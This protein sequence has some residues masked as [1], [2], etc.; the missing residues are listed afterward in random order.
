M[1]MDFLAIGT[2]LVGCAGCAGLDSDPYHADRILDHK[3][4][5]APPASMLAQPGPMVAGPGPGV[6]P[7][8][9]PPMQRPLATMKTQIRFVRPDGMSIGWLVN[10]GYAE[11]QIVTPGLYDFQQ[12]ATYRLKLTNIPQ[13]E[14]LALYP[15]LQVYPAHP[16]TD[17][18]LAHNSVPIEITQEDLDQIAGS[19]FVTKVIYLPDERFQ[20]FAIAGVETL[21]STRLDPGFDPVAEADRRGTIMVVLRIGNMDL[22]VPAS[23]GGVSQAVTQA[24]YHPDG[25]E[26]AFTPPMPISVMAVGPMG[27]PGAMIVGGAGA[28]GQPPM[29]PI[30]GMGPTPVWGQT[31]TGTPIGLPGPPHLP[32]GAPA[33]L[34]S[35]TIRNR[36][37]M[38]LPDPV[39]HMLMDVKHNP[40]YR[41]PKPVKYIEYTESH[42][43]H[44]ENEVVHPAWNLP[45]GDLPAPP[46]STYHH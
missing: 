42:P 45:Q 40:G 1:K 17:A 33:S 11:N 34:Q 7:P 44:G 31:M 23:A 3:E 36:T 39:D 43:V 28:P 24:A 38:D 46:V 21:V 9:A 6:M 27:V 22:E 16:T 25:L 30:A 20:E 26:G 5:H 19:N 8:L 35:H 18:Y 32:F 2:L 12:G 10:G 37:K 15:T 29:P 13:R 14:G 4:Y 41:L